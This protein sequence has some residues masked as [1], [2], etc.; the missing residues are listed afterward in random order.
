MKRILLAAL[1]AT[2]VACG[3]DGASKPSAKGEPATK[4]PEP[5]P[6]KQLAELFAGTTKPKLVGPLAKV[7]L[8]IAEAKVAQ[9][10]PQFV[11][12]VGV[13][14]SPEF[15]GVTFQLYV[16]QKKTVESATI[17]LPKAEARAAIVSAWGEPREVEYRRKPVAFW[18]NPEDGIRALLTEGHDPAEMTLRYERYTP[19][20]KTLGEGKDRF[21]FETTPILGATVDTLKQAYADA[22]DGQTGQ[23]VFLNFPPTEFDDR[24]RVQARVEGDKVVAYQLNL[25]FG[26]N[27]QVKAEILALLEAKYGKPTEAKTPT[28][29]AVMEFR[30]SP[31]VQVKEDTLGKTWFVEVTP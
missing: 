5:A 2:T 19:V 4:K 18:F 24:I 26:G 13:V 1:F 16:G 6:Q 25:A 28:G 29:A 23:L 9:A 30:K 21:G 17:T 8:G 12:G 14:E 11:E 15:P 20:A 3:N 22:F 27:E 7:Q 10:A 31:T